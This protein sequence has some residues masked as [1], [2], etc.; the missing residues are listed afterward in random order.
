MQIR[1]YIYN[2]IYIKFKFKK[3]GNPPCIWKIEVF[4]NVCDLLTANRKQIND[5]LRLVYTGLKHVRGFYVC[6]SP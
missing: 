5:R 1:L 4:K 3:I 2:Q 6:T